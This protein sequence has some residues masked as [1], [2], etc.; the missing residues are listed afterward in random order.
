MAQKQTSVYLDN[1]DQRAALIELAAQLDILQRQ[2]PGVR[3]G[4]VSRMITTIAQACLNTS[5]EQIA[6]MLKPVIDAG[7][8]PTPGD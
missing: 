6:T 4:N 8:S 7:R 2:Y 1:D 5:P 3:L